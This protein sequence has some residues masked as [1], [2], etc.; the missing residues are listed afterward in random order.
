MDRYCCGRSE[1][2]EIA[3]K[4]PLVRWAPWV[5]WATW[6]PW[7]SSVSY[8]SVVYSVVRLLGFVN[9]TM[10][11]LEGVVCNEICVCVWMLWLA[12]FA[13]LALCLRV[14]VCWCVFLRKRMWSECKQRVSL[15]EWS[16][17]LRSGR[18][19]FGLVGSNPTADILPHTT[20]NFT[21]HN[22]NAC[23][24]LFMSHFI[25]ILAQ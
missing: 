23:D 22:W 2:I 5:S 19:V 9:R 17:G 7:A 25:S 12:V 6:S 11:R 13:L 8:H 4:L 10:I 15:P 3:H 14:C 20:T 24:Y 18:N 16:K 21:L 1:R